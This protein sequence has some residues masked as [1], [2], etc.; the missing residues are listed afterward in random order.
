LALNVGLNGEQP[1]GE[2]AG[3]ERFE[4]V[5]RVGAGGMGVV[6]QAFDRERGSAVA[7][8]T[9]RKLEPAAIYHLKQE[10]RVLADVR[11]PNLVRLH[12]LVSAEGQWFF[13]MELVEGVDFLQWVRRDDVPSVSAATIG[14]DAPASE[15]PSPRSSGLRVSPKLDLERLRRSLQQLV[16]GVRALH[17]AGKLHRDIKPSNVVVTHDGRVVLL[18]FGLATDLRRQGTLHSIDQHVLGTPEYM[19][20]EQGALRTLGPASDWYSVG[21]VLFEALTG[22]LPFTGSA[23][24]ILMAKERIDGPSPGS[25][26]EGLPED[27]DALCTALLRRDPSSR[28]SGE[29][30]LRRL[31]VGEASP[32]P[33]ATTRGSTPPAR[34]PLVGRDKHVELLGRAFRRSRQG[35]AV[36]VHLHG[37]AGVGKSALLRQFVEEAV[38]TKQALVLSGAC[39]ERESV[40]YKAF[41]GVIDTLTRHLRRLTRLQVEA[42]LPRDVHAITRLFPVLG[43]V[44]AIAA[45]P[46]IG[47]DAPDPT[48]LRRRAFAA[49]RELLA[50]VADRRPLVISIDDLQWGDLDSIALLGDLLKPPYPPP[51]MIVAAFRDEGERN[52]PTLRALREMHLNDEPGHR[53]GGREQPLVP[54]LVDMRAS[55][56]ARRRRRAASCEVYDLSVE[57]LSDQ[58]A[59]ALASTLFE[60]EAR[61]VDALAADTRGNPFLIV[62]Y[63]RWLREH[64][65]VPAEHVTLDRVIDARVAQMS[66]PAR[67]ILDVLSIAARPI[68]PSI[69]ARA[70]KLQDE[71]VPV[72]ELRDAHMVRTAVVGDVDALEVWHDQIRE[73]VVARLDPSSVANLHLEL[74]NAIEATPDADPEALA[75]HFRSAGAKWKAS[76]YAAVAAR[77]AE[78]TLAFDRAASLFQLAIDLAPANAPEIRGHRI[79]R[80]D[81]LFNAGRGRDAARE[82]LAAADGGDDGEALELHRRAAQCLLQSGHV[83]EGLAVFEGVLDVLGERLPKSPRRALASL[84]FRRAQLRLRGLDYVERPVEKIDPLDLARIDVFWAL[85]TGFGLVDVIVGADFGT[86]HLLSALR[87][88]D[89]YR[90]VRAFTAEAVFTGGS[91]IPALSRTRVLVE[92]TKMLAE[93][94]GHPHA[95]GLAQ[96]ADAFLHYH[97]GDW[98]PARERFRRAERIFREQC[99]GVAWELS[100]VRHFHL[101]CLAYLGELRRLAERGPALLEE[102]S[103]RGD[104]LAQTGI[105][106]GYTSI[107]WLA[108]DDPEGG[109]RDVADAVARWSRRGFLLQHFYELSSQTLFDLYAG[110]PRAAW[111]R[112]EQK[113]PELQSSMLLRMQRVRIEAFSLRGRTALAAIAAHVGDEGSLAHDAEKCARKI[114]REECPWGLGFVH[115][116]RAGLAFQTGNSKAAVDQLG[117]AAKAFE[118]T[119]MRLYAQAARR[120]L[121]Q[122]LGGDHGR[123]L[124]HGADVWMAAEEV[125]DP[126]RI[127]DTLL[128]GFTRAGPTGA[129][130]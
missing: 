100:N 120:K 116:I 49:M 124:I 70:A 24:E 76:H 30:I 110:E 78:A 99:T 71:R 25:M 46:R 10:F 23:L 113:W 48:E 68:A 5:R 11:H 89:T 28:P 37:A 95:L 106:V 115:A 69:A 9:L 121:G 43:R 36:A 47:A 77:R 54:A 112:L 114:E 107:L 62:E 98:A 57:P 108:H 67:R 118:A 103:S 101:G 125:Q 64:P 93:K 61:A 20:P 84:F 123:A 13:T 21:V 1:P 60:D 41:D 97:L 19:S 129:P 82:Y 59:R 40:P 90:L 6:Y 12:E 50:R 105:R 74:A 4:I 102:A 45:A 16:E 119:H 7:L 65:E 128:P 79:T 111:D 66:P 22:G 85:T 91:G 63:V 38:V 130:G 88:G 26:V 81:A 127:A 31:S 126:A 15:K 8:K 72:R 53:E 75:N 39:Y 27:L 122:L 109:R 73:A 104:L 34:L 35:R 51:M 32:T 3:T 2:F 58:D 44:E 29:E 92:R 83:D 117:R 56:T 17:A 42:L 94:S 55:T 80:A 14:D 52:N 33:P 87:A 86:R 96:A 18:D